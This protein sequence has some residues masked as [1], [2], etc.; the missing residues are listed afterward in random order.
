MEDLMLSLIGFFLSDTVGL[1]V[2]QKSARRVC[3]R[4]RESSHTYAACITYPKII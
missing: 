3:V 2:F 4:E 1:S